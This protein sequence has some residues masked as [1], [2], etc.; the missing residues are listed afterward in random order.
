[1]K[2]FTLI[3]LLIVIAIL[4]ALAIIGGLNLFSYYR[5]QNL[6]LTLNEITAFIR[7]A[8]NR[9]LSQQ[10]GNEWGIRFENA[11]PDA[12]KIF[13]ATSTL[14]STYVLRS[15]VQ[16]TDPSEGNYKNIV[17][18]KIT[19]LPLTPVTIKIALIGNSTASST[20][21]INENGVIQY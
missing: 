15:G 18:K 3:E 11:T 1:M 5:R 16:F 12:V 9:S 19:G 20:I 13:Y 17:F 4:A 8:Q 6:E 10:D 7:D 2:G 21:T 14:V